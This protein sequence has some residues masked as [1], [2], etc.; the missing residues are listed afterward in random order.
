MSIRILGMDVGT[1]TVGLAVSDEL[2]WTAQ[3]VTTLKRQNDPQTLNDLAVIVE[4][5]SVQEFVVGIPLHMNGQEGTSVE[6]A[7]GFAKQVQERFGL[8]V[9]EWDERLSTVTAEQVLRQGKVKGKKRK[10]V[11]DKLAASVILQGYLDH[12]QISG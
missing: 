3:P 9:H 8:P 10:E 6:M 5:Y 11:V 1:K 12:R 7:R 2:G 4:D